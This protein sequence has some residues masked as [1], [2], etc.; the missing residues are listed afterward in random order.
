MSGHATQTLNFASTTTSVARKRRSGNFRANRCT[1]Q[2]YRQELSPDQQ[3]DK[4]KIPAES[5]CVEG[6]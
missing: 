3:S 2:N 6:R 1:Y 5:R 4:L